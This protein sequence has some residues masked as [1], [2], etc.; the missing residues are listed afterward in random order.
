MR[1]VSLLPSA[2]EMV[3]ALGCSESLVGISHECD[4][5]KELTHL[6]QLTQSILAHGLSPKQI[7]DAVVEASLAGQPLYS[8]DAEQLMSLQPDLILTQGVCS[9]CAVTPDT[10]ETGFR[11]LSLEMLSDVPI[12]S[13]GAKDLEGV[14]QDLTQLGEATDTIQQAQI[15][16]QDLRQRLENLKEKKGATQPKVL[17][18]EW[19]EPLWYGGHWV[20][21]QI[22]AAG[23]I[24]PFGK[25]GEPSGRMTWEDVQAAAPEI[26]LMG[27]CGFDLEGNRTY[28]QA[29]YDVPEAQALPAIQQQRVYA[30]NSNAYLS[31]PAPRL[32]D[33]AEMLHAA[34]QGKSLD[35]FA[36]EDIA[37]I[38]L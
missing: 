5:P 16:I 24:D 33:G 3:A 34:I 12:L 32:I 30:V 25:P 9:V 8:V 18:I 19:P 29:L 36:S 4:Y 2:T 17:M 28:A 11:L 20:P 10:I 21:E 31:R 38:T 22:E 23:G 37:H 6:P 7:D 14:F 27:A 13:F 1:I 15:L 26:I 35:S